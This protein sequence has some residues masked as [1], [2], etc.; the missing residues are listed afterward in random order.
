[1]LE[2]LFLCC[3][4]KYEE[5]RGA[6]LNENGEYDDIF[7]SDGTKPTLNECKNK[8]DNT[9][10]CGAVTYHQETSRCYGTSIK[11]IPDHQSAFLNSAWKCYYKRGYNHFI[12]SLE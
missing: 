9:V 11:V 10:G 12:Y 4:D 3:A 1:M 6:C 2:Y 5:T 7:E 8:C